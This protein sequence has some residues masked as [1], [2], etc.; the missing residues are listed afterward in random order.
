MP[1]KQK[2]FI[3]IQLFAEPDNG[4]DELTIKDIEAFLNDEWADSP[5]ADNNENMPPATQPGEDDKSKTNEIITRAVAKRL[6][7]VA[8]KAIQKEREE[9]A[10]R[11]GY[12]SYEAWQKAKEANML[13]EKGLDP[14]EVTPVVEEII[15]KRLAEDPRL[16]E[17]EEF[18]QQKIQEWGRKE[19]AELTALT[20]GKITKIE[21]VPKN[22]IDLWKTEGSL[23]AAYLKIEGEKLIKQMQANMMGGQTKG[24]TSHLN[25]PSGTPITSSN[26]NKRP[27]TQEE[28]EV[29][30][31]F[32]PYVTDEELNKML[33]DK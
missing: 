2:R 4:V 8:T 1:N 23:K 22:V 16:K 18:R 20:G 12:E 33:K 28:K 19:L 15:Q 21:D 14:D 6:K 25:S 9:I 11:E 30:K 32:N 31:L 26:I 13:K 5:A 17:L 10:K 27:L 29:Y 7:D 3:N 24:S